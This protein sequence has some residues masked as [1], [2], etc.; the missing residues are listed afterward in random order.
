MD[1][2]ARVASGAG[3]G[4]AAAA[5]SFVEGSG[6]VRTGERSLYGAAAGGGGGLTLD[7]GPIGGDPNG[8]APSAL[9]LPCRLG[10]LVR[11]GLS[12]PTAAAAATLSIGGGTSGLVLTLP[13]TPPRNGVPAIDLDGPAPTPTPNSPR[14]GG[15]GG[16]FHERW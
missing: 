15:G 1:D 9:A 12:V 11:S 10:G 16:A 13:L 8:T 7:T 4:A 3:G 5:A 2:D 6:C 14:D